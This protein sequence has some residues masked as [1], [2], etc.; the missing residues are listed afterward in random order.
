MGMTSSVTFAGNPPEWSSVRG[1]L[2]SLGHVPQMRMID[3]MP[4]F[5]DE[6]P[7]EGWREIRV[8]FGAGMVTIRAE[9]T[10]WSFIVWGNADEATLAHRDLL[11]RACSE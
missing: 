7:P 3:G 9:G 8:S 11:A 4:A 5:P 2:V 10:T 6:E 1:R